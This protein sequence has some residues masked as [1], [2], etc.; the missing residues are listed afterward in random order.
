M[1]EKL[2]SLNNKK[3]VEVVS[4]ILIMVLIFHLIYI[5]KVYYATK[6]NFSNPL[7]PKYL[8]FEVF[9][10]FAQKGLSTTLGLVLIMP[11]KFFKQNFIVVL[12]SLLILAIYYA[13]SFEPDFSQFQK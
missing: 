9:A 5:F 4:N 10:P 11:L 6:F 12:I 2:N 13:T 7:I 1:L 8:A 3:Q